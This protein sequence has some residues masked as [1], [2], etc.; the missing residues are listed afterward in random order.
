MLYFGSYCTAREVTLFEVTK[1]IITR[2]GTKLT[3]PPSNFLYNFFGFFDHFFEQCYEQLTEED[4]QSEL[5]FYTFWR[6]PYETGFISDAFD[7]TC[8]TSSV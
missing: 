1:N 2:L 8:D 5:G 6:C 7:A 4:S 3:P